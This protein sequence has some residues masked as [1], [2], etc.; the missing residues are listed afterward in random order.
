M[1]LFYVVYVQDTDKLYALAKRIPWREGTL[2]TGCT[3]FLSVM[4]RM[5]SVG[6]QAM[7]VDSG[8]ASGHL[9]QSAIL[10]RVIFVVA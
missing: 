4:E 7:I 5:A 2:A 9:G 3:V 6:V 10:C 8:L 1:L